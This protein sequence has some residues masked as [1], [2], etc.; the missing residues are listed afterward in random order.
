MDPLR[1]GSPSPFHRPDIFARPRAAELA[2]GFGGNIGG[3]RLVNCLNPVQTGFPQLTLDEI[4]EL[5]GGPYHL[6]LARSYITSYRV[7]EVQNNPYVNLQNYHADRSQPPFNMFG[8]VFDQQVAPVNWYGIWPGCNI[9]N[10]KPWEP[11][12]FIV[13][14]KLPSRYKS[15]CDHT[16][17]IAFVPSHL[18]VM[19]PTTGFK[20]QGLHRIKMYICGPR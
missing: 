2:A 12:R 11:V 7:R 19:R 3:V 13:L 9:A 6:K 15:N 16:V 18:P 1:T 4:K 8:F 5:C 14:P 17:V 10:T 20:S